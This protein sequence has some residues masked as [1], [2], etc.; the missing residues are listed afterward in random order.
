MQIASSDR[1]ISSALLDPR[2]LYRTNHGALSLMG[3]LVEEYH[4]GR[5]IN[6]V[7]LTGAVER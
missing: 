4:S 5:T 7:R 1:C 2:K 3:K 6:I